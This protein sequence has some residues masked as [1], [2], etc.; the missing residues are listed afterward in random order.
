VPEVY[1]IIIFSA[2]CLILAIL[3]FTSLRATNFA[4]AALMILGFIAIR[5]GLL[6]EWLGAIGVLALGPVYLAKYEPRRLRIQ[7]T[8]GTEKS[9]ASFT[10]VALCLF[11]LWDSFRTNF[12]GGMTLFWA[13]P[14][15]VLAY[16]SGS[17]FASSLARLKTFVKLGFAVVCWQTIA[18]LA[19]FFLP[20]FFPVRQISQ[21]LGRDW[22]YY[23]NDLGGIF[24]G[25][26]IETSSIL[27]QFF[28]LNYNIEQPRLT[29][30]WGEP[31]LFAAFAALIS[32]ADLHVYGKF[33]TAIQ[34]PILLGVLVSQSYGGILCFI[35]IMVFR[36]II[37]S[38]L[39]SS[40]QSKILQR[41]ATLIPIVA[42]AL[43]AT[44]FAN[45][46]FSKQNASLDDRL[47]TSGLGD[48]LTNV[49]SHPLGAE[50]EGSGI[51]LLQ[52]SLR[53]GVIT[54]ILGLVLFLVIPL[55]NNAGKSESTIFI[56]AATMAVFI[57]PPLLPFWFLILGLHEGSTKNFP[58]PG[59]REQQRLIEAETGS[60]FRV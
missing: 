14:V 50:T 30:F 6:G 21:N 4:G 35:T 15:A 10:I 17:E 19:T 18:G 25:K 20:S 34:V 45:T 46:K 52:M 1:T 42:L 54:L 49:F 32:A 53:G 57:E 27:N 5:P 23:F 51:N 40:V 7:I 31:A 59:D 41:V 60:R 16:L 24:V 13:I 22:Q 58:E 47:G 9:S 56:V 37:G 12:A 43:L 11:F 28:G 55:R 44:S 2:I 36:L 39:S 33:R 3:Y 29:S 38:N 26:G 8:S 48:A